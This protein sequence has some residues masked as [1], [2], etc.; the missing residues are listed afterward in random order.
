RPAAGDHGSPGI[1]GSRR[2]RHV[3]RVR[4]VPVPRPGRLVGAAAGDGRSRAGRP[5]GARQRSGDL[6]LV[7][8]GRPEAGRS[9]R[10]GAVSA[11]PSGGLTGPGSA[12]RS[13]ASSRGLRRRGTAG[14]TGATGPRRPSGKLS[15]A[16]VSARRDPSPYARRTR[17]A[18][19]R[20]V[21]VATLPGSEAVVAGLPLAA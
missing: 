8:A 2:A 21:V 16:V 7:R 4:H 11:P 19:A 9:S 20:A 18:I 15:P 12:A 10:G 3:P 6:R 5:P 13:P 1:R 17:V 14:S